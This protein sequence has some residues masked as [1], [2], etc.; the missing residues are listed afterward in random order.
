MARKTRIESRYQCTECGYRSASW[1][2]RCPGCGAWGAFVEPIE[3]EK[4]S[5]GRRK[6]AIRAISLQ[7][8]SSPQRITSDIE[9]LDRVLGG[10]WIPGGVVLL[11]GEPGIGKSTLLLQVCG[12]MASRGRS[13]LY[14]SGEESPSQVALRAQRLGVSTE[15]LHLVCDER[16]SPALE[17][18]EDYSFIVVDSV[19]ALRAET[20]EGWPGTPSQVRAVA[21]E[22]IEA[23]KRKGVP[24]VLVGHITKQ[25]NIA[26]PK[27]LEH[28]VDVVLLF[29]G[30]RTSSHRILRA[31]KN[32]YGS[33]DEAGIFEMG[34]QG[35][36]PVADP[37]HLFWNPEGQPASGVALTVALE[38][39]RPLVTEVQALACATPFQ[40]PKRTSS[41]IEANRL[42][43]LL[44]VLDKRC[45]LSC[46]N[47]DVYVNVAGGFQIRDRGAD[48]ALCMALA[49]S[50]GDFSLRGDCCF[51][52]EVGL[53]GEVRSTGRAG[54]RV[55]EA[56]RMGFSRVVLSERERDDFPPGIEVVKVGELLRALEVIR[57]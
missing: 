12:S 35:L 44:A 29:S 27:M 49:S 38:G 20:E 9:E 46:R 13:V 32:R 5:T 30:E 1:A 51:L 48:L 56:Q 40:Y 52:G 57:R 22:C 21:Q 43:L 41:G 39:T 16:I 36:M 8:V 42:Q 54:Q 55:R 17:N 26:G 33:V 28:M 50:V 53:A 19:Q 2:G 18:I 4:S 37:G 7:E 34:E 10:G 45:G 15:G 14:I 23:A 6:A 3:E 31:V 24:C 11:G 25:G 47:S